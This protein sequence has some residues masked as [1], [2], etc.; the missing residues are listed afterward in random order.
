MATI[1]E[2]WSNGK[3][4]YWLVVSKESNGHWLYHQ[5]ITPVEKELLVTGGVPLVTDKG[6]TVPD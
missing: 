6:M 2:V 4:N 3:G 5:L 1:T